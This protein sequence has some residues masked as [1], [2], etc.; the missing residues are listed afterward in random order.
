MAFHIAY[1][2]LAVSK[3]DWPKAQR[4]ALFAWG[5]AGLAPNPDVLEALK[6]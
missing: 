1:V 2:T 4:L 5:L 3:L 6:L